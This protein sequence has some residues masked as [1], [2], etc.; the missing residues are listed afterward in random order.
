MSNKKSWGHSSGRP[1]FCHSPLDRTENSIRLVRVL[2]DL[3]TDGLVRCSIHHARLSP[4]AADGV[5]DITGVPRLHAQCGSEPTPYACLSYTWGSPGDETGILLNG[6]FILVRKN[7]S[8]F[9]D[10]ARSQLGYCFLWIDALCIDQANAAERDHQ[11]QQMGT[12]FAKAKMLITWL[13][14]EPGLQ[15]LLHLLGQEHGQTEWT[16]CKDFYQR[17]HR[18]TTVQHYV[19][20]TSGLP[21]TVTPTES[22]QKEELFALYVG[23]VD[24]G[25]WRR[26]WVTQEIMLAKAMFT[27]AGNA[28]IDYPSLVDATRAFA[29]VHPQSH[30]E[31]FARLMLVQRNYFKH[32]ELATGRVMIS[33]SWMNNWGLI[34]LLHHF[35][36]KCCTI[37]R[38][39]VYSVLS[40]SREAEALKV[41][42]QSPT[43]EVMWQVMNICKDSVCLCTAAVLVR[44]L[45]PGSFDD[46]E[47]RLQSRLPFVHV[48]MLGHRPEHASSLAR[49]PFCDNGL[50]IAERSG[51]E[52]IFC[53]LSACKDSEG[54]IYQ[55]RTM[56]GRQFL[57]LESSSER[58]PRSLGNIGEDIEVTHDNS[59]HVHLLKI[60][61]PSLLRIVGGSQW[62]RTL[63]QRF[64]GNLWP[65]R[66][67][68]T[69]ERLS[70]CTS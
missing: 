51:V 24:H 68:P 65:H 4:G 32:K 60:S 43:S 19:S 22:L 39:M 57:S 55:E 59:S 18:R 40:L 28:I 25:Y 58:T 54:H 12:I 44:A 3:S 53:L 67:T 48:A 21:A 35:E 16:I 23:L 20:L 66:D 14:C 41:N 52:Q 62:G 9:L 70:L 64:C 13:G 36:D 49:C 29:H 34:N 37:R 33:D 50:Q 61:L 26:A 2:S 6:N 7:L 46:M 10:I 11:V 47:P 17:E 45:G 56:D 27:V 42:Y 30:F 8:A 63:K 38:D 1:L 69:L 5:T 15:R 31:Q